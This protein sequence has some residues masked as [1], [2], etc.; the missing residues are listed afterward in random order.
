[1]KIY[2]KHIAKQIHDKDYQFAWCSGQKLTFGTAIHNDCKTLGKMVTIARGVKE[3]EEISKAVILDRTIDPGNTSD[4]RGY[5][6]SYF[7]FLRRNDILRYST[8]TQKWSRGDMYTKYFNDIK[9]CYSKK[10]LISLLEK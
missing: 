7:T 3:D 6:S 5:F 8:K 4:P 1:M 9:R 10:Y 2:D